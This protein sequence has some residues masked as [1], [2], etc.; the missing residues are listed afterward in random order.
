MILVMG[1]RY[2]ETG[3][4]IEFSLTEDP[5]TCGAPDFILNVS[6]KMGY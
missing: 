2:Y 6:L 4:S 5:N 1:G 3:R